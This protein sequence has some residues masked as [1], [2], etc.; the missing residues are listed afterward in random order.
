MFEPWRTDRAAFLR[1]LVSLEGWDVPEYDID[2]RDNDRG[3]EPGN[4]RFVPR[5]VNQANKRSVAALHARV[6][7]LEARLRSCVCGAA[8]PLHDP[9]E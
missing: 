5:A 2:R 9:H 3:Y 6:I 8:E 1:Y 4:L 7:E